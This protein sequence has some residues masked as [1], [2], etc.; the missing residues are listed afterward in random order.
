LQKRE[1]WH[2]VKLVKAA[3]N[4]ASAAQLNS[5]MSYTIYNCTEA[6]RIVGIL[7]Q[8]YMPGKAAELLDRLGVDESMREFK[9]ANYGM[10]SSY[11]EAKI[12]PGN[13]PWEG[14]FPPLV[15]DDAATFSKLA[16]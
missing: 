10:D 7:L 15:N 13:G 8:P 4:P 16:K 1:P 9:H 14:L 5:D 3:P 11:G 12:A 6:M 2:I